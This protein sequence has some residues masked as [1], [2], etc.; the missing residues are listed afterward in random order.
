MGLRSG[1]MEVE[2][3]GGPVY[4]HKVGLSKQIP[5]RGPILRTSVWNRKWMWIGN[6]HGWDLNVSCDSCSPCPKMH[7]NLAQEDNSSLITVLA[8]LYPYFCNFKKTK[9]KSDLLGVYPWQRA[10]PR[11]VVSGSLSSL[12]F[13]SK[14]N[15]PL[16]VLWRLHY[17]YSHIQKEI[18]I[19]QCYL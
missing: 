7:Y 11:S 4:L 10:L 1:K 15:L 19:K 16:R 18:L 5:H 14:I 17:L 13:V 8:H 6:E 2:E 9:R 3:R 12:Y